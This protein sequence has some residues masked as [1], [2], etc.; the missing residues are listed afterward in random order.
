MIFLNPYHKFILFFKGFLTKNPEQRLGCT[1]DENEI[2]KHAFF[3][4][5]DWKELEKRNIKPPF[6]PKMVIIK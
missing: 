4:K 3:N 5:L 6:R 2:R 1:G